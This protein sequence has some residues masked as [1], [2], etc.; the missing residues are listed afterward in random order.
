[1]GRNCFIC[2]IDN[3]ATV[4]MCDVCDKIFHAKCLKLSR[5]KFN[6]II[7]YVCDDCENKGHL[8]EWVRITKKNV[9]LNGPRKDRM[10]F[11]VRAIHRHRTRNDQREFLVEWRGYID[12]ET[13]KNLRSW[14]PEKNLDGCIDLLQSYCRKKK[15][16]LSSIIGL[17]GNDP[18]EEPEETHRELGTY[19]RNSLQI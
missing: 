13:N 14:E 19:A 4:I 6:A 17:L 15:I 12:D 1:M 7:Q 8:T 18:Q 5:R 11:E 9:P 16:A 10:Y 3:K 2:N